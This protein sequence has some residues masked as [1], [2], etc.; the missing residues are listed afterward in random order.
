MPASTEG[1]IY[2]HW[3]D[4]EMP[5]AGPCAFCGGTDKRHRVIDSI[6]ECIRAGD[7]LKQLADIYGY[8]Q[9]FVERLVDEIPETDIPWHPEQP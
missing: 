5:Y 3:V 8:S 4:V 9:G 6:V 7:D 2:P 1:S